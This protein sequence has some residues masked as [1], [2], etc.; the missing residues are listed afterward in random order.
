MATWR[1]RWIGWAL[2]AALLAA[3]VGVPGTAVTAA[4]ASPSPTLP[5]LDHAVGFPTA[6]PPM[7]LPTSF[8]FPVYL[9]GVAATPLL[10][11]GGGSVVYLQPQA[12]GACLR[13]AEQCPP[14]PE[15]QRFAPGG[16]PLGRFDTPAWTYTLT[17]PMQASQPVWWDGAITLAE[18]EDVEGG[19]PKPARIV[20][21]SLTG[22]ELSSMPL[23]LPAAFS[24]VS[25]GTTYVDVTPESNGLLV[26]E[27]VEQTVGGTPA[28]VMELLEPDATVRWE[29]SVTPNVLWVG[30]P[31]ILLEPHTGE[32]EA[33]SE[34]DGRP[35]WQRRLAG[36]GF[37]GV[38]DDTMFFLPMHSA[39]YYGPDYLT[40]RNASTGA[41]LWRRTLRYAWFQGLEASGNGVVFCNN[42]A[43]V[44]SADHSP[45]TCTRYAD[46]TGAPQVSITV[47]NAPAGSVAT[48]LASSPTYVLLRVDKAPL[49]PPQSAPPDSRCDGIVGVCSAAAVFTEAVPWSGR[50]TVVV[51]AGDPGVED[52]T[53]DLGP[54]T[55]VTV[56]SPS[57]GWVWGHLPASMALPAH[58]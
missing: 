13:S 2:E 31:V 57:S 24:E 5:N 47:P 23:P 53:Y 45:S 15:I 49:K 46:R 10:L 28:P 29:R 14:W 25:S 17:R 16:R 35:I 34:P 42:E 30:G 8:G 39:S 6:K 37:L 54:H 51:R 58:R 36:Q 12:E 18:F 11:P 19:S 27:A 33:V 40:A 4:R 55:A 50:G 20:R 7:P 1:R 43:A 48:P 38:S 3:F 32:F 22:H 9:R 41:V 26:Y 21:L 56:T 52:L 44:R